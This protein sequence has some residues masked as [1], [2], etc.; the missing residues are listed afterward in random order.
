MVFVLWWHWYWYC[1]L[2]VLLI[3]MILSL[4]VYNSCILL[5]IAL[6]LDSYNQFVHLFV[7]D[8]Q[9]TV[10]ATASAVLSTLSRISMWKACLCSKLF[11]QKVSK[12]LLHFLKMCMSVLQHWTPLYKIRILLSLSVNSLW[13]GLSH[14]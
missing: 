8:R 6:S 13:L 4:F 7:N 12:V 10:Y 3:I 5:S 2:T 1:M 14:K 9:L 11:Y